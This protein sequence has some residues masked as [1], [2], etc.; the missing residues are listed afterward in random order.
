MASYDISPDHRLTVV[1]LL[2]QL[3][4]VAQSHASSH[5]FGYTGLLEQGQAWALASLWLQLDEALPIGE[6]RITIATAVS[7][8]AGPVV[9]RAYRVYYDSRLIC[10]GESMWALI[11][12][13]TRRTATPDADLRQCLREITIRSAN[14]SA[15]SRLPDAG[16][17][18]IL[19]QRRVRLHDCD[20]NGHLNNTV[21][22]QWMLDAA[23]EGLHQ[24][25]HS[26]SFVRLSAKHLTV[27]YH[28]EAV[29]Y[30]T[31]S[32]GFRVGQVQSSSPD[33]SADELCL[34]LRSSSGALVANCVLALS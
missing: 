18:P 10:T 9:F 20:F 7:R 6:S 22:V 11:D 25:A 12:L 3:H 33:A 19:H 5:G 17:Y 21:M 14:K 2:R 13:K 16:P 15:V 32:I 29:Q 23:A 8:A 4:D 30:D 26:P 28:Q 1:A 24:R 27:A 31:I 34:D